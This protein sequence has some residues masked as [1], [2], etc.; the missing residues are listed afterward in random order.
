MNIY[1]GHGYCL[2]L[3]TIMMHGDCEIVLG[4]REEIANVTIESVFTY[5]LQYYNIA[6]ILDDRKTVNCTFGTCKLQLH[7]NKQYELNHA[8]QHIT[9]N[10]RSLKLKIMKYRDSLYDY[11][12]SLT[13][14][15]RLVH[16]P[17]CYKEEVKENSSQSEATKHCGQ[18]FIEKRA[19]TYTYL[20]SHYVSSKIIFGLRKDT[21]CKG[22]A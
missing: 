10:S 5:H 3:Q 13:V 8:D 19:N 12:W 18:V 14:Y 7:A 9:G 20:L 22:K 15:Y 6:P 4:T 2:K 21:D 16:V 17:F 1:I 11:S